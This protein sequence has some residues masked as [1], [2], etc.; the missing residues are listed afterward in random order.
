MIDYGR[1]RTDLLALT[2]LAM[3]VFLGLSLVSYDPADAPAHIVYPIH[4]Q[5]LN[6]CGAAGAQLAHSLMVAVG[7]GAY[8]ILI[9]LIVFDIRLFVRDVYKDPITRSCG[10]VLILSAACVAAHWYLPFRLNGSMAGNGGYLGAWGAILLDQHF[11][12]VG[13]LVLLSTAAIAG[14]LLTGEQQLVRMAFGLLLLPITMWSRLAFGRRIAQRPAAT[15]TTATTTAATATTTKPVTARAATPAPAD[16]L[17]EKTLQTLKPDKETDKIE[18]PVDDPALVSDVPVSTIRINAPPNLSP[19]ALAA[20]VSMINP[21]S[22][23]GEVERAVTTAPILDEKTAKSRVESRR[24]TL[25]E[26]DEDDEVPAETTTFSLSPGR[27]PIR[28][29]PPSGMG[30][31]PSPPRSVLS[32]LFRAPH[33]LPETSI[34]DDAEA[35]P[36]GL[37]AAKA[38]IAAATLEKTFQE[39][40]LN[41]KVVEIDTGPVITQF[42]LELEKGLRLSKVTSLADDLAI[43]LRVSSV[44]VIAPIPGKNTVGVEVPNDVRVMV[45]LKEL[46]DSCRADIDS[47]GIPMFLGKDASGKPL[48]VDMCKMP[49]LLIA[50]RT[51]TGKSVCLNTLI[52]SMLMT[53][54]PDQVKML[55]IDPKMVELSPYSRIPHLMH[56]VITDMKK[57]EAVL[58]WAVEKMEERYQLLSAVGVRHIDSFNKMGREKV[59]AKL[60]LE[61]GT[62]EAETVPESIPYIVI[63]ADEM[64]DMMM[65]SGKDVEGHIIRLAQ[66]SRAVGIHLVL[67]TQKPTVDVIT[68]LIKSN[69]PARISFQVASR[70]DSRVVLDEMGAD[71][72]LGKGDMLYM[73]P[74]TSA[75]QRAQGT[76]VSDD[77]VN[78]VIEFFADQEPQYDEELVQ[79]KAAAPS[80]KG[81]KGGGSSEVRERDDVYDEAVAVV[82]REGRGSVSLLQRALGVG[83]GRGARLID[84]MAED[85]VVGGYNGS[86][87]REVIMSLDEWDEVKE[88][89]DL[90]VGRK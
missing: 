23:A 56:P 36:Y 10:A 22:E 43:A 71:K 16:P 28:V 37:L 5:P 51:G 86:Q 17:P 25:D 57:A 12:R 18:N 13:S 29:N 60:G 6:L 47:K 85:G 73:A 8:F 61:P 15:T 76:Y 24:L 7:A 82:I 31:Q 55:M 21:P 81:S 40:G 46:I 42:E 41:V 64:A 3:A 88:S 35:F 65:T 90:A 48:V 53:R 1:L 74:E 58:G 54:S 77:E 20:I 83:Y 45:R 33:P 63:I 19:S 9:G 30:A 32:S 67:A 80:S 66:K 72:L 39:F 75:L 87:A 49:H 11:S 14:L 89:R 50:G 27:S 44:R 52:V 79:L 84:W 78:K 26:D 2:V 69:L 4:A 62:D 34:L 70:M 68:G 59:L 38:Q